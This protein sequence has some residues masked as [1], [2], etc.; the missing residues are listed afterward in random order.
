[1]CPKRRVVAGTL[2]RDYPCDKADYDTPQCRDARALSAAL[3]KEAV[4]FKADIDAAVARSV[5]RFDNSSSATYGSSMF[6]PCAVVP[7]R[8]SASLSLRRPLLTPQVN[9]W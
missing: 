2:L 8:P 7:A 9:A 1:M 4:L 5:L 3:L 6:V